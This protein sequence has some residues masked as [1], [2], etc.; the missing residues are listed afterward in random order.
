MRAGVGEQAPKIPQVLA[1]P[2]R[3]PVM[4]WFLT[5]MYA[6]DA[7][8]VDA[9]RGLHEAGKQGSPSYVG[10]FLEREAA[11]TP[12]GQLSTVARPFEQLHE[13]GTLASMQTLIVFFYYTR[14]TVYTR[15]SLPREG[16]ISRD[17]ER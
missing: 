1:L 5:Q 14:G 6:S 7:T 3:K 2:V 4:P 13:T 8:L 9:L 12:A 17:T 15:F 10:L 11:E 16:S